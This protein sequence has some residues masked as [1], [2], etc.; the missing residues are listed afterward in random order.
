MSIVNKHYGGAAGLGIAIV[1]ASQFIRLWWLELRVGPVAEESL[2]AVEDVM[3]VIDSPLWAVSGALFLVAAASLSLFAVAESND[4]A[5]DRPELSPGAVPAVIG[6]GCFLLLGMIHIIGVPQIG[7]LTEFCAEDGRTTLVAY[8]LVRT[9]LLG[10]AILALGW[11]LL[12]DAVSKLRRGVGPQLIH[13][14]GLVAAVLCM[15]FAFSYNAAP[16]LLSTLM[17]LA[18]SVWGGAR[19]L[20]GLVIEHPDRAPG[21]TGGAE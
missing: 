1:F 7:A 13:S 12:L 4:V 21:P 15:L 3:A 9:V 17:M 6:S 16:L 10:S 19:A 18:V 11:F 14:I 5:I 2:Y 20:M 8:N